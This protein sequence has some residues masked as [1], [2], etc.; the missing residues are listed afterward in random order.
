MPNAPWT[1]EIPVAWTFFMEKVV[2]S[3]IEIEDAMTGMIEMRNRNVISIDEMFALGEENGFD[4]ETLQKLALFYSNSGAI[5]NFHDKFS[6]LAGTEEALN[7]VLKPQWLLKRFASFIFDYKVHGNKL[8]LFSGDETFKPLCD[9]Y[10]YN[11]ILS[12]DLL[13][14]ILDVEG[15]LQDEKEFVTLVAEELLLMSSVSDIPQTVKH[16]GMVTETEFLSCP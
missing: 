14:L 9:L 12:H 8:E 5:L 1:K 4:E 3:E 15:C 10:R 13:G 16:S 11:G 2:T 6:K 7:V